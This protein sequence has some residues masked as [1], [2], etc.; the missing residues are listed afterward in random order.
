MTILLEAYYQKK[1]AQVVPEYARLELRL[2]NSG[3]ASAEN[4]SVLLA[5][6]VLRDNIR[7]APGATFAFEWSVEDY[8][9]E[10]EFSV[11]PSEPETRLKITVQPEKLSSNELLYIKTERLPQLLARLDAP[12]GFSLEYTGQNIPPFDFFSADYTAEKLRYFSERLQ[13]LSSLLLEKLD[14][15]TP[16]R[17]DLGYGMI[18]GAVR[19]GTTLQHWLNRPESAGLRHEWSNAH[20]SFGTLPNML[21]V[22][23]HFELASQT[24]NLARL[25]ELGSYSSTGLKRV[26]PA[27]VESAAQ[28]RLFPDN[29]YLVMLPSYLS[30]FDPVANEVAPLLAEMCR[31][32]RNPAYGAMLELWQRYCSA[33]VRL[34]KDESELARCGLQPTSK[35]YELWCACEVALAL[36]LEYREDGNKGGYHF[37]NAEYRLLYNRGIQGGWYSAKRSGTARPDLQIEVIKTGKRILLDMKYSLQETRK[38][39]TFA[40]PEDVYKMLAYLNDFAVAV[41]GIIYPGKGEARLINDGHIQQFLELPLRPPV[42]SDQL[43]FAERLRGSLL[44]IL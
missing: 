16:E 20:K 33:Y 36:R 30:G 1:I 40:N 24:Q 31:N 18:K 44:Q 37:A 34:P 4:L 25:V 14:Y 15:I 41:G 21:L 27:L 43:S 22:Y 10:L 9:G 39:E 23:F 11:S 28:H 29:P 8:V 32:A 38:G 6:R 17:H 2:H 42:N 13:E 12:N 5:R 26:L 35:I 7:L 19:W 3:T